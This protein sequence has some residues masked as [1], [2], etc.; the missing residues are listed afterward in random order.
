M[1]RIGKQNK[2][3]NEEG[4]NDKLLTHFIRTEEAVNKLP[5]LSAVERVSFDEEIALNHLYNS[6][7]IEG[8]HLS[9]TKLKKAIRPVNA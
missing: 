7:A 6:S 9:E 4:M 3:R 1:G 8:T 5:A 2:N